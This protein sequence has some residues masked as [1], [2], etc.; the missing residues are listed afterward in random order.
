MMTSIVPAGRAFGAPQ[1]RIK[2]PNQGQFQG[3]S[4]GQDNGQ[5]QGSFSGLNLWASA[6]RWL[7]VMSNRAPGA[8]TLLVA[9][10]IF[11]THTL[12][13]AQTKQMNH[14]GPAP[15]SNPQLSTGGAEP[16]IHLHVEKYTLSNGLKVLLYEDH[17]SPL[18]S[19]QTWFRVGSKYEHPGLTGI[20]HLFEHL[21]FKGSKKYTGEQ[22]D[23]IL[24]SNGA[25]N[26][27]F[28]TQDY[29][30]Y[31][32]NLPSEKIETIM[33]VE[34]DRMQFLNV[35]LENLTSEREVVKEERR[36]RVDNNPN[37]I[38]HEVL[39]ETAYHVHPYRWPV[40]G[41]MADLAN[42]TAENATEFYKTFYAPSNATLVI[43]GDFNPTIVKAMI[44]KHYGTIPSH[45]IPELKL[46]A[47]PV[48]NSPRSQFVSR[49][50]QNV[51]FILAYHT[52]K[53]GSPDSYA[54]DLLASILGNGDSSRLHQRLVYRD[55]TAAGVNAFNSSLQ[56][57]GLFEVYVALKPGADFSKA[58]RAAYGEIWRPRHL[59]VT[60]AE[61]EK[62]KNQLMKDYIDGLK[63]IHG[64]AES[65]ALN[66]TIYGDYTRLFTDLDRYNEVTVAQIRTVAEKYLAPEMSTI[67]VLRPLKSPSK[68]GAQ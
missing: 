26:N 2:L 17:S 5:S 60:S 56:D 59:G 51:S 11:M 28:T 9:V 40:I 61:L 27:A 12:A 37:G 38:L 66:E 7:H 36:Y 64:K 67:V 22:F 18:V 43:A 4:D 44:D 62:A 14:N 19:Y 68:K 50:V 29:T 33:D 46:A 1:V 15:H 63:S 8:A 54:L 3:H 16:A 21:M 31:Y 25:T 39:Y 23:Q 10:G 35:T 57:S 49:D 47:E 52:P 45:V 48:Q 30:G 55:Q 53:T 24:Q 34:A 13:T 32:E 20:A 42:V 6:H 41:S 58:Q 65:I